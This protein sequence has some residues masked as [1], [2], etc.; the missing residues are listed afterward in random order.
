[1]GASVARTSTPCTVVVGGVV[2]GAG[3][4]A[5]AGVASGGVWAAAV[6]AASR[7][8]TRPIP[9]GTMLTLRNLKT[10]AFARRSER[11]CPSGQKNGWP[12][13]CQAEVDPVPP[14]QQALTF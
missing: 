7:A 8:P 14:R 11:V 1:M 12:R 3:L 9:A 13:D 5:G 6:E 4:A 2:A 10:P